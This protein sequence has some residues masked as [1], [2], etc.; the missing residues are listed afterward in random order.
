LHGGQ[1]DRE[2]HR[3]SVEGAQ[4]PPRTYDVIIDGSSAGALHRG[5]SIT[6][7]VPTGEHTVLVSRDIK[8][9]SPQ[10]TIDL[11]ADEH[12]TLYA[13]L[14]SERAAYVRSPTRPSDHIILTTDGA[15]NAAGA[16]RELRARATFA[17]V[18]L[19]ALVA[20]FLVPTGPIKQAAFAIFIIAT[21]IG[22]YLTIRR[23]RH[24][25]RSPRDG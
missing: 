1:C 12:L 2:N 22:F 19:L 20:G 24:L 25:Y 13:S 8:H 5:E 16:P 15:L 3:R 4:R 23:M 10:Q 11:T 7:D 21:A 14:I 18:G 6:R 17:A 9:T